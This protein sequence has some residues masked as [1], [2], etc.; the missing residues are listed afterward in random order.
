MRFSLQRRK[1]WLGCDEERNFCQVL[2]YAAC[3]RQ[4]CLSRIQPNRCGSRRKFMIHRKFATAVLATL[5]SFVASAA[6]AQQA[7]PAIE[8]RLD[9]WVRESYP[10]NSEPGVAVLVT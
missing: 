4:F 2:T 10:S 3:A 5:I 1:E 7:M 9:A 6:P 8:Q